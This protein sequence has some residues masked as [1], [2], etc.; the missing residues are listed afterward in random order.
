M[1][2]LLKPKFLLWII[3]ILLIINVATFWGIFLT[4]HNRHEKARFEFFSKLGLTKQ[5]E[6]F[7][8]ERRNFYRDK[9]CVLYHRYDSLMWVVH[10]KIAITPS[11]TSTIFAI[12]DSLGRINAGIRKN[13]AMYS[14]DIRN[15]LSIS[16]QKKYDSLML[17]NI[18]GRTKGK[19]GV[20]KK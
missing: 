2:F 8:N 4:Q 15:T 16:Q 12:T 17:D 20:W 14:I 11:D 9:N 6:D 10:Q 13:W 18:L 1:N 7:F 5:Q 19:R 3:G